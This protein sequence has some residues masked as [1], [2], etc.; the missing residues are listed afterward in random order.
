MKETNQLLRENNGALFIN[1]VV[2][3]IL[4]EGVKWKLSTV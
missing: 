4:S 3:E 2:W 1:K